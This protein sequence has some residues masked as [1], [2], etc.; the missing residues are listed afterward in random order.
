MI[1]APAV[2]PLSTFKKLSGAFGAVSFLAAAWLV[3]APAFADDP[4]ARATGFLAGLVLAGGIGSWFNVEKTLTVPWLRRLTNAS[5]AGTMVSLGMM[6]LDAAEGILAGYRSY[7]AQATPP[8]VPISLPV[9]DGL[10]SPRV[11]TWAAA[12]VALWLLLLRFYRHRAEAEVQSRL[13]R[14]AE[15]AALRARLAPH[16]IFNALNTLKAQIE[17]AP[18]EAATTADRLASLFRQVLALTDRP[19]IPLGEELAFVEAYLGIERARLGTRLRVRLDVAED[20]ESAEVPSL[21]LQVLVENAVK[22]G[23]APREEGG[24]VLIWARWS[25][26]GS[27]RRL[28][29][30]V[31]SPSAPGSQPASTSNGTGTGLQALR[32]RLEQ[33][34]DLV[35]DSRGDRYRAQFSCRG[36]AA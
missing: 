3:Q 20:V 21:S 34:G 2:K 14:E 35:I 30:G 26:P 24:E 5:Q 11:A 7:G 27:G 4:E 17:L 16:F 13:R 23:I 8:T 32:G 19:T 12:S 15:E 33:P 29:V 1:A 36:L 18:G 9:A 22:H 10:F 25:G 28:L 31:E 6:V